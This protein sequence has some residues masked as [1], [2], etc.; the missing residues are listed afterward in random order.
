[1]SYVNDYMQ[2]H[3]NNDFD[4]PFLRDTPIGRC[5][6]PVARVL[7]RPCI[8][9]TGQFVFCM[10]SASV[11]R[12]PALIAVLQELPEAHTQNPL[13]TKEELYEG[14]TKYTASFGLSC[15]EYCGG[16]YPANR[17]DHLSGLP[18]DIQFFSVSPGFCHISDI[19][20]WQAGKKHTARI[21]GY[22]E[23]R[24]FFLRFF[25]RKAFIIMAVMMTG[26]I[27]LRVGRLVPDRFIAVFYTGL[28]ASLLLAG[29]L[30]G[31]NF[32]KNR[33][34]FSRAQMQ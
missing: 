29:L 12:I 18:H 5:G 4:M 1:M 30:F 3:I 28:G 27:G 20:F 11:E 22:Q 6:V 2:R 14:K 21:N 33:L 31:C 25:D 15:M 17:P 34:N 8:P 23:E 26:G 19:Y 7:H 13:L 24:H 16:E 32:L 9:L 10:M